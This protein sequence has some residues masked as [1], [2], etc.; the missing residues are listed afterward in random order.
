MSRYI[1]LIKRFLAKPRDF[2]YDE[3]VTLLQGFG[4]QELKVGKTSGSRTAFFN[5]KNKNIIRLHR[6]HPS[7]VLKHYQLND[8]EREL[9]RKGFLR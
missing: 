7:K 6:P 4:Y 3:L 8:V 5:E 1:K 2:T 9:K